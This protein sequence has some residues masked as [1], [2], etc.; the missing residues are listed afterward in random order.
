MIGRKCPNCLGCMTVDFYNGTRYLYCDLCDHAY[1]I[2][3]Y[4]YIKV[5]ETNDDSKQIMSFLRRKHGVELRR[6]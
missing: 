2:V 4:K 5:E 6:R 3:N 1:R